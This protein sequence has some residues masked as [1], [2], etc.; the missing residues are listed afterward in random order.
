MNVQPNFV[1]PPE[2][3][4]HL[5]RMAKTLDSMERFK[6]RSKY[7][8]IFEEMVTE[9]L[10]KTFD[11]AGGA[12]QEE[13]AE[14]SRSF[15][16]LLGKIVLGEK[17]DEA[18]LK[19]VHVLKE[20]VEQI[21]GKH[22][23]SDEDALKHQ[24]DFDNSRADS[25][26]Y[27]SSWDRR[28]MWGWQKVDGAIQNLVKLMHQNPHLFSAGE[29]C[30]GHINEP[31]EAELSGGYL[32]IGVDGTQES[33]EIIA[34]ILHIAE[35][36]GYLRVDKGDFYGN[37]VYNIKISIDHLSEAERKSLSLGEHKQE[38]DKVWQAIEEVFSDAAKGYKPVNWNNEISKGLHLG[39]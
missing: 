31:T 28:G 4:I 16:Q 5:S 26:A 37:E 33:R 35:T 18:V 10:S 7:D 11:G 8:Y 12:L 27:L 19:E 2:P 21:V 23:S 30:E 20:K 24:I 6:Q 9:N 1:T 13:V 22:F 36:S 39:F 14:I 3:A 29:S 38:Y 34:K 17:V 32:S 15:E 25:I